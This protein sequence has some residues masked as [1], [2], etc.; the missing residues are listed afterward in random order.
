MQQRRSVMREKGNTDV[1]V[2]VLCVCALYVCT[3]TLPPR[4]SP[5]DTN[6]SGLLGLVLCSSSKVCGEGRFQVHPQAQAANEFVHK[7][8]QPVL[9]KCVLWTVK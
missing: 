1:R 6:R 8:L 4:P 7:D 2:R 5:M 3:Y 9:C